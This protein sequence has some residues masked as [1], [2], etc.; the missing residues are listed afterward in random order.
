MTGLRRLAYLLSFVGLAL[1][2]AAALSRDGRP[3]IGA[4]LTWAV[5]AAA[6]AAAPG[7]VHRR[8]WPLALVLFP[9]GAF[10]LCRGLASVPTTVHGL[11]GQLGWYVDQ[12]GAGRDVYQASE[13][14]LDFH[15]VSLELLF[16]MI[17]YATTWLAG[18][19]ALSLR[20]PL[21]AVI[22][23]LITVGFGLTVDGSSRVVWLPL[24]FLVL[25]GALLVLSRSLERR[26]R[27]HLDT[28]AGVA[29]AFV[30][31]LLALSL[32]G[33]T[34]LASAKPWHDWRTWR[35]ASFAG[36]TRLLF[37]WTV[38]YPSLLDP[39]KDTQVMQVTSPLPDYWRA[40]A[41]DYFTG[42]R[43]LTTDGD[44]GVLVGQTGPGGVS[45]GVP[46]A[47]VSPPGT[48]VTEAFKASA[49]YTDF[50]FTGGSPR[51]IVFAQ[52]EPIAQTDVGALSARESLGPRVE[53][54]LTAVVPRVTPAQ[55][56]DRG[57]DY[58][59]AAAAETQLPFPALD[60]L[61]AD[62]TTRWRRT[63]DRSAEQREWL[64][65]YRVDQ[66]IVGGAT[67][68]YEIAL[69]IEQ[70]LSTRYQYSLTLPPAR[71]RSPYAAFLFQT[72]TGYCQQFAGA[73]AILL[74]FNG[75]PARVAVG[76]ATGRHVGRDTYVVH[77]NDAHAWVEAYFPGTGWVQF[78]PTPGFSVPTGSASSTSA[79]FVDPFVRSGVSA[80]AASVASRS[81]TLQRHDP[82]ARS[83][84]THAAAP[85]PATPRDARWAVVLT[86]A[87]ALLVC[88]PLSRSAVRRRRLRRGGPDDRLRASLAVLRA[89]LRDYGLAVPASQTLEE[90]SALLDERLGLDA[91]RAFARAQAVLFGGHQAA[92]QDLA[93]LASLRRATRRRLRARLGWA[94]SILAQY[95]LAGALR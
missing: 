53:Y 54:V 43:W 12:L 81:A 67:D 90:T 1:T 83:T 69:R 29:T 23:V 4:A 6:L 55:L 49:I 45:Y 93:E 31:A 66:T 9:V 15:T 65:L 94:R 16:V 84:G 40:N 17:V 32:L 78:D 57:R 68:P 20:R 8:A 88:W 24:A 34:S 75:V 74:R 21:P 11:G 41:L 5:L 44:G 72:H 19:F 10:L 89:D 46:L 64:P 35:P 60:E 77:T 58:P 18:L 13:F 52:S 73:M 79:G 37:D 38:N 62:P 2:G 76:F 71:D 51:S 85:A 14:P 95:G 26:R 36:G 22:V 47:D 48:T 82:V 28:L 50:L 33:V 61:G 56:V 92:A 42:R 25:A 59:A 70:Y 7:L 27:V 3:S 63:M 30:A 87:A 39:S 86:L 80:A 91:R